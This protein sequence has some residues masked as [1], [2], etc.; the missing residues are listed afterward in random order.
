MHNSL[1]IRD[2]LQRTNADPLRL[3]RRNPH[4]AIAVDPLAK[5]AANEYAVAGSWRIEC[6]AV[7][8]AEDMRDFCARMGIRTGVDGEHALALR[9][10]DELGA[11]ACRLSCDP[12]AITVEGG[13]LAGLWAGVA[14][15]EW[16]MRT[17][18]GAILPAGVFTRQAAWPVQIS[19]GPWGGNYSV[20]DF[21]PEYLS[22]DAF[23][24]YAHYGVN[25][26]MIYGDL[27]C[28]ANSA[29]LPELNFPAAT[30]NLAIL[31]DAA[32]R[33]A[34]YGVQFS[35]CVVGPKL[36]SEHPVFLVHPEVKG[37]GTSLYPG[38][39]PVHV[40]CA[41]SPTVH[42]F[43]DEIFTQLFTA[44]PEL[45]GLIL[46]V[47]GESFYH[48]GMH[49]NPSHPCPRCR[50]LTRETIIADL[51]EQVQASVRRVK[52]SA[53]VAAWAY[54]VWGWEHPER[55]PLVRQLPEG[56]A[57]YHHIEKDQHLRKDGYTKVIWDYSIDFTGPSDNMREVA[58]LAHETGR[59]LFVKTET[60]IGLEAIQYPYL[61]A[62]QRLADKWQRVREL[63]P[64][65]V[66]QSWLFYG[67]F[68]TR[69]E[70]L[71]LWAAYAG[72]MERDDFLR[73]MA[74]RDFGPDAVEAVLA[75]WAC[76][77][78]AV[79]H[80]PCLSLPMYYIG[81]SFLG[82]CHPLVPEKRRQD[83]G[84][85]Q[86]LTPSQGAEVP[87]EFHGILFYLQELEET[88]SRRQ[89]D[90]MK[91]CLVMD[92]LPDTAATVFMSW[93]G[94][95]DGW[96][97]VIREYARA[98]AAAEAAWRYL[99]Q[100]EPHT[101]TA[102]DKQNLREETLLTELIYRTFATCERTVRFLLARRNYEQT[103]D[104]TCREEMRQLA[105]LERENAL[106]A[107]PIYREAP[108]LDLA[109]RTDGKFTPCAE[110]IA[111][112]VRWIDAFLEG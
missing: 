45:A 95:G 79:G 12:A 109:E 4:R 5:P 42:R 93:E 108:W 86:L 19:Q 74:T 18:R 99:Q 78:R 35:Y 89:T 10:T 53:Y 82:P 58:A 90:E 55:L 31:R 100:A 77:S 51:L 88:F 23:R 62:M 57:I 56:V 102:Q 69:A 73:R 92:Q 21:S 37:A 75:S 16:E 63:A 87:E 65:G 2:L 60:G 3:D 64:A 84:E 22:D 40:L 105:V 104:E 103:G 33:A 15:L 39:E 13:D 25:S 48:C 61:P 52:P 112:K 28:Y 46:I 66:Q 71:G 72:D 106:A 98:T 20:P 54:N 80:I 107:L 67:M 14:W 68:G 50:E 111:A 97:I 59:P 32:K 96:D 101:R 110:M 7:E 24:L 91:T 1:F 38:Q 30:T 6:T 43:Y 49:V 34:R 29:V 70:E 81:P 17:R 36:C 11:R 83:A 94:G 27:L 8:V 44:A 85:A 26:M 47:G 9:V 76:M 41:S